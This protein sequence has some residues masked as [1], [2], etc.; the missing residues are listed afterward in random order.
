MYGTLGA[1]A[2][3]PEQSSALERFLYGPAPQVGGVLRHPLGMAVLGDRLIVCD[4][5][6]PGLVAIDLNTNRSRLWGDADHPPRC[7]VDVT[8]DADGRVYV[9]DTTLRAVLVH[10]PD[11]GFD[12]ALPGPPERQDAFRPC[13]LLAH[14][15]VLY[16]GD[17][18]GRRIERFD[19]AGRAYL[20]PLTPPPEALPIAAP[21][22]IA[23]TDRRELLVADAIQQVVH[24][25]RPDG[26]WLDP[27]GR[28]GRGRG[29]FVR[30][31]H[32]AVGRSGLIY[33]TDS[34]RQSLLVFRGD[35]SFL[36]EIASSA[37]GQWEGFSLPEGL[38]TL[39]ADQAPGLT[40]KLRESGR[41]VPE[42]IV[43]V[44]DALGGVSLTVIG[45]VLPDAEGTV[46]VR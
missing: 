9:A 17:L 22:G 1:L 7:P 25:I 39:P 32:V 21:T 46:V 13:S 40:S 44:S 24:R 28:P 35:G 6:L 43:I 5:G 34:G 2:G 37:P 31:K 30:P 45:I 10:E 36:F 26:T 42:E 8:A 19:L 23:A 12:G 27:V 11:E 20:S 33:V 16:V 15:G 38:V 29:Q 18:A 41:D 3:A 4:Q 14:D